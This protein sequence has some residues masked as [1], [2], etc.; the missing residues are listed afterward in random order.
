MRELVLNHVSCAS[1]DRHAAIN[2]LRDVAAGM[3]Q[4]V[5]DGV[6]KPVLRS[7]IPVSEID[8]LS[9]YS[10]F[11]AYLDLR[12]TG[13]RDS[14][15]FLM[16]LSAKYP[17]LHEVEVVVRDRF[18]ACESKEFPAIDGE[19]LVLCAITDWISVSFPSDVIWDSDRLTIEFNELL[20][21]DSVELAVESI[22]NVAQSDHAT[23]IRERHRELLF[24]SDSPS[25]LWERRADVFP[26]L[27]FGP[28]VELPRVYFRSIANR[29]SELDNSAA[30]WQNVESA[31]PP[32][33]CKVTPESQ[34]V[35]NNPVLLDARRF[36]SQR[37]T[38]DLYVWHARVGSGI[39]IHL[40]FDADSRVIEIG[41][42]GPHLPL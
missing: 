38:R 22:D 31:V 6:A 17:I 30:L 19:P 32:W 33:T 5:E 8:C 1:P 3:A 35:V 2:W 4:L 42:I 23:A 11:D 37:G 40:R 28:D 41:Y 15:V 9:D 20:P 29:L 26:N 24:L 16:R 12:S 13:G 39:R 7:T 25:E 10:L 27:I 21:N 18:L 34:S 14:Y 36:R